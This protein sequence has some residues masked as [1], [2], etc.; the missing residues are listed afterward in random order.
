MSIRSSNQRL[1]KRLL[2][3][4]QQVEDLSQQ[5]EEQI[6][7]HIINRLG[8]LLNVWRFMSVWIVLL[9]LLIGLVLIQTGQLG[10]YYKTL[11]PIPGGIYTE[12]ILG[13]FTTANPLYAS[14]P[15][16]SAVSTLVFGSLFNYD[17]QNQL[18]GDLA[19]SWSVD[20]TGEIYTVHLKPNLTWQDGKPLTAADVVFTYHTIQDPDAQSPLNVSWQSVQVAEVN[21]LAVTFTLSNPLSSFP[22]SLT[23]GI[24]PQHLLAS[25]PDN[26]L[27]SANFNT[28]P[29]GSGPFS[30]K[31]IEVQGGTPQN[32]QEQI[33][34]APF[35]K[36]VGGKPK[37]SEFI[38]QAYHDQNRLI[39]SFQDGNLNGLSGLDSI[40]AEI[41][42]DKN[43]NI[44]SMPLTAANMVFFK[45]SSGILADSQVRKALVQAANVNQ[46][47]N[48]L[49]YPVIP[50]REPLLEGQLGFNPAYDQLSTNSVAAATQLQSDGWIIGKNGI[51]YK[52]GN[53]LTFKL[54]TANTPDYV[55]VTDQLQ[56]QWRTIGV[57]VQ[58]V[59]Q[60][61]TDLQ[62]TVSLHNYDALLYG[63][64]I[65]VDPD[66]FVYWDSSQASPLSPERLNFSEYSSATADASLEGGRTRSDPQLRIIKY[67]PF[68]QAWQTD[69]PALGLYQPR[70]LYITRQPVFGLSDGPVNQGVDRFK[71]VANWQILQGKVS[72]S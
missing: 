16:D 33:T 7:L 13:D 65:G 43:L 67:E 21:S 42:K 25:T 71:N 63:I 45:T 31:S 29:V 70:F 58:V 11:E 3:S 2:S 27:R 36:Y 12:G 38:I 49:G 1:R 53:P 34:L 23:N 51:R 47:I 54:F 39:S 48:G 10:D 26:E 68:L 50:V 72:D 62:D 40:P 59:L 37:L 19:Q 57:N 9:V 52:G 30:W 56:K 20:S 66:V 15:V 18:V 14:N 55:Y 28:D 5:A 4:K 35:S 32:R 8:R 44:Y 6:D 22:Y 69:A 61:A 64:S 17:Q 46:I 60:D 41:N 24:I